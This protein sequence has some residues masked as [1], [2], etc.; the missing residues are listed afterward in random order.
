MDPTSDDPSVGQD[1]CNNH[2]VCLPVLDTHQSPDPPENDETPLQL[3]PS[4]SQLKANM[5]SHVKSFNEEEE[6]DHEMILKNNDADNDA[7]TNIQIEESELPKNVTHLLDTLNLE[8]YQP[9]SS[10]LLALE[11]INENACNSRNSSDTTSSK[12]SQDSLDFLPS[13]SCNAV[14]KPI[15]SPSKSFQNNEI[16]KAVSEAYERSNTVFQPNE[17]ANT[18]FQPNEPANTVFQPNEPANTVFQPNEPAN[19][20]FQPN[21]SS[22]TV[23]QP[24]ESSN[25]VF[26]PNE[27]AKV[28]QDEHDEPITSEALPPCSDNVRYSIHRNRLMSH[29]LGVPTIEAFKA[30][31]RLSSNSFA[32]YGGRRM[33]TTNIPMQGATFETGPIFNGR[34]EIICKGRP[35]ICSEAACKEVREGTTIGNIASSVVVRY[36]SY[37]HLKNNC[38]YN[39]CFVYIDLASSIYN[40]DFQ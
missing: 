33:S 29:D 36:D 24:N 13:E 2:H 9:Q 20:V 5:K 39:V 32:S 7:Q 31:R 4:N 12:Q 3:I 10:E 37:V 18:V 30:G 35:R 25:T 38:K 19:T 27:S 8:H 17:P 21:E 14:L 34:L 26:Q 23:F 28:G 11:A 22:N 1:A 16:S 40:Q 6:I 15:A